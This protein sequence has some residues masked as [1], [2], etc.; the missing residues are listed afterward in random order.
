MDERARLRR[1][2]EARTWLRAGYTSPAR[3]AE[4]RAKLSNHRSAEAI[5]QVVEEMRR[6]WT[7]RAEWQDGP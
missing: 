3:I 4:L 1:E 2:C 6:Q 7:R 5:E